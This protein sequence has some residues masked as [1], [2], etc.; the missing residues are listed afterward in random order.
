MPK[1]EFS[2]INANQNYDC[3]T[4]TFLGLVDKPVL[5][6]KKFFTGITRPL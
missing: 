6:K 3:L 5:S 2:P 4:R 1:F